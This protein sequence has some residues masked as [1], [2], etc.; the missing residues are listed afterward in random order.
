MMRA[1]EKTPVIKVRKK[2]FSDSHFRLLTLQMQVCNQNQGS[3]FIGADTFPSH[4]FLAIKLSRLIL[5]RS[6]WRQREN[7]LNCL[8]VFRSSPL[9]AQVFC[10]T[11][12]HKQSRGVFSSQ[13]LITDF[14][15]KLVNFRFFKSM[16]NLVFIVICLATSDTNIDSII[17][18]SAHSPLACSPSKELPSN[19]DGE[20]E[21]S[22]PIL[23]C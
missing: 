1:W 22:Q 7:L 19:E 20:W 15:K 4:F 2:P 21:E 10:L 17:N 12:L 8:K 16:S 11:S 14:L 9:G 13:A 6:Q 18:H 5:T 3:I 23:S